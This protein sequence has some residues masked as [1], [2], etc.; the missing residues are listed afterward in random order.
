MLPKVSVLILGIIDEKPINPYEINKLLNAINIKKWFP[1]APSSVY[2]TIRNLQKSGLIAGEARKEG[3]TPEKTIYSISEEGRRVLKDSIR[4]YLAST[5]LDHIKDN[6]ACMM[7]C[8]LPKDEAYAIL[9][10]KHEK[11]KYGLLGLK[12]QIDGFSQSLELPPVAILVQKYN[13]GLIDNELKLVGE[14]LSYIEHSQNWNH[15]LAL[16]LKNNL[17]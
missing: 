15:Y 9:K 10:Q 17:E 5:E 13:I 6:I 1:V 16:D 8:H 11:L 3:N 7:I 14:L 12:K 2:A 4:E